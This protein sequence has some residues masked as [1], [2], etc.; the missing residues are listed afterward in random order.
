MDDPVA[1]YVMRHQAA[2]STV[3]DLASGFTVIVLAI[4]AY[5]IA[6][7]PSRRAA[8]FCFLAYGVLA[9][10]STLLAGAGFLPHAFSGAAPA[11]HAASLP[12]LI[13]MALWLPPLSATR[14]NRASLS[15]KRWALLVLAGAGTWMLTLALHPRL[16]NAADTNAELG[17][18]QV[19]FTTLTMAVAAFL[20][21][22]KLNQHK[23]TG[24][25]RE[26]LAWAFIP[27]A[28]FPTLQAAALL[29]WHH[30]TQLPFWAPVHALNLLAAWSLLFIVMCLF[31]VRAEIWTTYH[32][33]GQYLLFVLSLAVGTTIVLTSA[34]QLFPILAA[35][36]RLAFILGLAFALAGARTHG[37]ARTWHP[38]ATAL[39]A[40][41]MA[42]APAAFVFHGVARI[43]WTLGVAILVGASVLLLHSLRI[44]R[45]ASI[46][47]AEVA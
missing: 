46:E 27:L 40:A 9:G 12:F 47:Q 18:Q 19:A 22:F 3:V 41:L 17:T 26:V 5:A 36:A 31:V 43:W 39:G 33:W 2:V 38:Y 4:L 8:W 14:A 29:H 37:I 28:L 42:A 25:A 1:N 45:V 6:R 7:G 15:L 11:L 21:A 10:L 35:L 13:L 34:P 30:T 20:V 44:S 16:L 32:Q 23:P 24:E